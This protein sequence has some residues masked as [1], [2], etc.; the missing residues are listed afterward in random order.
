MKLKRSERYSDAVEE[1]EES[2]ILGKSSLSEKNNILTNDNNELLNFNW[3]L[4]DNYKKPGSED[5]N[6]FTEYKLLKNDNNNSNI[7]NKTEQLYDELN[8]DIKIPVKDNLLYFIKYILIN[9]FIY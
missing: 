8:R 2:S 6:E 3:N 1:L 4:N 7:N 5:Q 9:L